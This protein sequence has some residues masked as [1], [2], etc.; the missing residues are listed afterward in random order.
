MQ[1]IRSDASCLCCEW[2][3]VRPSFL[4]RGRGPS[5]AHIIALGS[6]V[7]PGPPGHADV[8][9][10]ASVC[11]CRLTKAG[12]STAGDSAQPVPM[13]GYKVCC[14][15]L[16]SLTCCAVM[17]LVSVMPGLKCFSRCSALNSSQGASRR[18]ASRRYPLIQ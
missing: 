6:A 13:S 8:R 7:I 2:L 14:C 9:S 10:D 3:I 15:C 18:D 16:P 11:T 5:A 1:W 4:G 12:A 17:L